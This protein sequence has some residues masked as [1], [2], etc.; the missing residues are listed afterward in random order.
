MSAAAQ[1][2]PRVLMIA[3][4][5]PPLAFGSGIERTLRF[6]Q[7]LP[8]LGWDPLVLSASPRA[9]DRVDPASARAVPPQ[10][11]V[12][13]AFALD[14]R[15]DLSVRGRYLAFTAN[16]DKWTS[17][18][19]DGVRQGMKL[20]GEYGPR[21]IWSTYPIPT[22]HVIAARLHR[23][24]GL[25]WIAD[26]RDPMLQPGYP[27]IAA[28]RRSFARI[29]EYA[30]RTASRCVFAAPGA[31]RA[32]AE[33]Y[34]EHAGRFVLLENGYDESSF[35]ESE[36]RLQAALPESAREPGPPVL[37]HSGLVYPSE[38]DPTQ[39][40]EALGAL[41]RAGWLTPGRLRLRFR[42]SHHDDL[43][44]GLARRHGVADCIELAPPLPHDQALDEMLR[45]DALLV[46]QASNCNG[47]I[48]AK[49]Y[50]YLRA[51]RPILGL[52]DPRG[53]TAA[54]LR[55]AGAGALAPLDSALAI[56]A[57]LREFVTALGEG[58]AVLPRAAAVQA[59]S[60]A[61]RTRFLVSLLD[62]V[63]GEA[64]DPDGPRPDA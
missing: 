60:R 44:A 38:R 22:A 25:P 47:Q 21:V 27:E 7:H 11:T 20:I 62:T 45:A 29:E 17:W 43:L 46:M 1:V 5:F 13:R 61:E 63:A 31:L 14:A 19:F 55:A 58:R 52:T 53:D 57:A 23:R 37:L 36:A 34:P 49:V 32:Y 30:V 33:R 2:P 3:Y 48:P 24:T 8:A 28:L 4:H 35:A 51:R 59:A 10:V 56:E 40:F 41:A 26:F 39:L 42:A 50:E 12:R 64:R 15:R 9:Y 16:P 6:V 54:T 18:R